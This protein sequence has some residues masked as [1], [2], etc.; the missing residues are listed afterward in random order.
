MYLFTCQFI[1]ECSVA[2]FKGLLHGSNH[3]TKATLVGQVFRLH[4]L[5][6]FLLLLRITGLVVSIFDCR[7]WGL[8]FDYRVGSIKFSTYWVFLW[9]NFYYL[10]DRNLEIGSVYHL[11]RREHIKPSVLRLISLRSCQN[12]CSIGLRKRRNGECTCGKSKIDRC[13]GIGLKDYSFWGEKVVS[14]SLNLALNI[15]LTNAPSASDLIS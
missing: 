14:T 15:L 6:V 5:T 8:G 12:C 7:S 9:R 2:K 4:E 1:T 13:G 10:V 11:C 3:P